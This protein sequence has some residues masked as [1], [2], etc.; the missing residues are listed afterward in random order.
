MKGDRRRKK[1]DSCVRKKKVKT[2]TS[3]QKKTKK[4]KQIDGHFVRTARGPTQRIVIYMSMY[5]HRNKCILVYLINIYLS[6][7]LSGKYACLG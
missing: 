5:L 4:K 2:A 6:I 7:Y 3:K 1:H